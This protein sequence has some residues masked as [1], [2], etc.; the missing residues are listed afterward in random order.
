MGSSG[1]AG[2]EPAGWLAAAS[3][4]RARL[5]RGLL[6]WVLLLFLAGP[7]GAA[8]PAEIQ[9]F[10]AAARQLEDG[11][12]EQAAK[13]FEDF[14][15]QNPAA[16]RLQDANCLRAHAL[17]G[18]IAQKGDHAGAAAAYAKILADF[19][20]SPHRLDAILGEAGARFRLGE[21]EKVAEL[22]GA[23]G[24]QPVGAA[25]PGDER[26]VRGVLLLAEAQLRSGR[27][28]PGLESLQKLAPLALPPALTWQRQYLLARTQL[29]A[30]QN[31]MALATAMALS[32]LS[33]N[34]THLA[35]ANGLQGEALERLGRA[36]EAVA[37]YERNLPAA[38]PGPRRREAQAKVVQLLVARGKV[39]EAGKRIDDFL[40]QP[41]A[42]TPVDLLRLTLAELKLREYFALAPEARGGAS[43]LVLQALVQGDFVLT[44]FPS[45]DWLPRVQWARGW[46]L[47][48]LSPGAADRLAQAQAAFRV[49]AERLPDGEDQALARFKYADCQLLM[50][51]Y[52][53]AVSNYWGLVEHY[54][55]APAIKAALFDQALY[56]ILRGAIEL[57]DTAAADRA[58][59]RLLEWFP[60]SYF[61]DR[62][63]LL[64]GQALTRKGEPAEARARFADFVKRF[65]NSA[66]LP[67]A[68][69]AI[70]RTHVQEGNWAA[71]VSEIEGLLGAFPEHPGRAEMEFDRAWLYWQSGQNTNAY[72]HYT[73]FVAR[74]PTNGLAPQAQLWIGDYY[75]DQGDFAKAE[76][77]YQ[78]LFQ[79][80]NW[81]S[82]D[83]A[84]RARLLAGR[85]AFGRQGYA[86][87]AGYF[88]WVITN[89]ASADPIVAEALYD[90]GITFAELPATESTNVL[91]NFEEAINAFTRITQQH[92]TNRMAPLAWGKIGDCHLQLA[93]SD[94]RRY[95]RATNAYTVVMESAAGL[96]V[97]SKAEVGLGIA[98]EKM[99][100]L[101]DCSD[102]EGMLRQSLDHFAA[103]LYEG[104]RRANEAEPADP[105]WVREAGLAAARV[106]EGQQRW[107]AALRIYRRLGDLFPPLRPAMEKRQAAAAAQLE[108]QK[109]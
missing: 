95:A 12:F 97:R 106:A 34:G 108:A 5:F 47:W 66:L 86:S 89:T 44:N 35:E 40:A 26:V 49:A 59:Q 30:A 102:R 74:F 17:A 81:V 107:E 80:T 77:N 23:A 64:F 41:T 54:A 93:A 46:S 36:D 92:A 21:F 52:G 58:L 50:R 90:L 2:R 104:N 61:G 68:R 65:P 38:T 45:S 60:E 24:L 13:A 37:A 75:F 87:A 88:R 31:E 101:P 57:G 67:E 96:S 3:A 1:V 85:A 10:D 99:A 39:V 25:K 56:Q 48:E 28:G 42:D 11:L 9:T 82:S 79:N 18:A 19:P 22:L 20:A 62:G 105:F 72:H 84:V 109:P 78:L 69:R 43:N 71:A 14:A 4:T 8:T 100:G 27:Y 51:D 76:L 73:N 98:L 15:S 103:V 16:D 83:L 7:L 6:G 91:A 55:A 32:A 63:L 70:V 29:A 53:G 33:T 94:P